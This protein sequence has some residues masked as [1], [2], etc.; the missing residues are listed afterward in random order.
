MNSQ[1]LLFLS[2]IMSCMECGSATTNSAEVTSEPHGA[3]TDTI[4]TTASGPYA[5]ALGTWVSTGPNFGPCDVL[6]STCTVGQTADAH[7]G[8]GLMGGCYNY[9][10]E[11]L[12]TWVST[13]P[14]F[15]PCD[16]LPST[17]I[18]G[19]TADAHSGPG[20]MGG[21]YNYVCEALGTWVSTGPG[22]GPCEVLPSTCTV[23]QTIDAHSGPGSMGGC[24]NYKCE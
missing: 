19:Q 2:L 13:G 16:V 4:K 20:L 21:C 11:A 5:K 18:V 14:N 15:G 12:G 9:V 17:C 8:P 10:C 3:I 1:Q 22:F 6:P 24:Y 23:G 7:S